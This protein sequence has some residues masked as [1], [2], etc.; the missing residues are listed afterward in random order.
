M[1][2]G[3]GI[4]FTDEEYAE[5]VEESAY[6]AL[7][8]GAPVSLSQLVREAVRKYIA[9]VRTAREASGGSKRKRA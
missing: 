6:M 9:E 8:R 4:Y 1:G 7:Q 5:L 3:K 2:R